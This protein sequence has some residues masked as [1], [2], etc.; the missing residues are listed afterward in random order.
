[1][2]AGNKARTSASIKGSH[3]LVTGGA[4]FIGSCL[5]DQLLEQGASV[6]VLDNFNDF[7][8]TS[9]KRD[10]IQAALAHHNC[11]LVEGDIRERD[12]MMRVF[13]GEKI[14]RVVH[15]AAMAGVRPSLQQPALY[16]D[17]NV[18]G[19]QVLLDVCQQQEVKPMLVFASSSSVYGQRHSEIFLETDRCDR[20][21]SPYAT[22]KMAGEMICHAAHDATGID[23]VCLRFFTAYGPR[24]RPDL[25]IHK[26]CW[27]IDNDR[28]IEMY[29]D[30]SSQRD[31]TYV[32]D[33]VDGIEKA[34]CMVGPGF[35]VI[36]LGRG[37]P[38]A[39]VDMIRA[40]ESALGREASIVHK[41]MQTGDVQNTFAGI[42]KARSL[43]GYDPQ[44]SIEEGISKFVAWYQR[45]KPAHAC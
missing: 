13:A 4:G 28:P 37:E 23:V 38:V 32:E 42:D 14:D 12:V 19:T 44:T 18:V 3:V 27:L 41:P 7:Y 20:P 26:F 22:S 33:M 8:D 35:E 9:V 34:L 36:N 15:L 2:I 21:I 29:G 43:L 30:G 10:N 40:I 5:V 45:R 31:Y 11:R 25:A 16:M 24:Q 39:L 6:T 17:V 1:M